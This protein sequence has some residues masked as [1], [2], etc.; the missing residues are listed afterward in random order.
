MYLAATAGPQ[1]KLI[2]MMCFAVLVQWPGELLI[3]P[4]VSDL[5]YAGLRHCRASFRWSPHFLCGLIV[6]TPRENNIIQCENILPH[7]SVVLLL[8]SKQ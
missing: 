6:D 2:Q 8:G 7:E 1:N 5:N 3:H 4:S